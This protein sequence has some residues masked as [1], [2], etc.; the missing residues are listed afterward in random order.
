MPSLKNSVG[1]RYL[2]ESP[3]IS[4]DDVCSLLSIH[5]TK[6]ELGQAIKS[7]KPFM[8]FCSRLSVTRAEVTSAGQLGNKPDFMLVV[9]NDAYD[10]ETMLEYQGKKYSIYKTFVRWDGYTE[11]YC[12]L[13][14]GAK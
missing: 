8:V 6:D 12:E 10:N 5:T 11:L 4:L 1:R 2:V 7:E 3:T 9:D 14:T 13:K